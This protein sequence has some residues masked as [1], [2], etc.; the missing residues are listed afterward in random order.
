MT[1]PAAWREPFTFG[2]RHTDVKLLPLVAAA[3]VVAVVVPV[4]LA[5]QRDPVEPQARGG[6]PAPSQLWTGTATLL[7]L[8]GGD[9]FLCGGG[10]LTSLPPA[11]CGGAVVRGLDPMTVDG[12]ERYANGT[13]TTPSVRLVGT[14]DGHALT[15]TQPA[16][17]RDPDPPAGQAGVPEP[18][19]PE[20]EG[21]WPFDRVDEAGWGRVQEYAAAQPDAG[22]A[23]VDRS[24]RILTMPFT[25]DLDRHRADIA[26]IYD[27]P[28]CVEAVE[29][30]QRELRATFARA[31][32]DLRARGL[33]MLTGDAGGSGK[34]YVEISVV[35]V[36]P[37][38]KAEIES[39]YDGTLRL[40]SFLTQL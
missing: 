34:P 14:W 11:G 3:A 10:V 32:S 1:D 9:V 5:A 24:Q 2:L 12:A 22:V 7:Q 20:P 21:G 26:E 4:T 17:R 29:R 37:E 38:E 31:E 28:V 30:S 13:I 25:G 6:A 19:C 36:T 40:D 18:S 39:T 23:R 27:G 8:S 35:A 16:E 33:Q 15:V